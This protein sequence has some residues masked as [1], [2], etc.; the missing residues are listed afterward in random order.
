MSQLVSLL[1]NPKTCKYSKSTKKIALSKVTY[2]HAFLSVNG[3]LQSVIFAGIMMLMLRVGDTTIAR[4]RMSRRGREQLLNNE[5][6]TL[7]L[8]GEKVGLRSQQS[9]DICR[10]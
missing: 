4:G 10:R 3:I 7:R 2:S 5:I 9:I 6:E 8:K 1:S